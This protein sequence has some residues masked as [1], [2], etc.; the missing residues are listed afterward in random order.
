MKLKFLLP[1]VFFILA[2]VFWGYS[3][4]LKF[5]R[6]QQ[7]NQEL[8]K[9]MKKITRESQSAAQFLNEGDSFSHPISLSLLNDH[10]LELL[11]EGTYLLI[12]ISS[13]CPACLNVAQDLYADLSHFEEYGLR[14]VSLSRDGQEA[15]K[16][17]RSENHWPLPLAYDSAGRLHRLFSISGVPSIVLIH[18]ATVRLKADAM[19]IDRKRPE[20]KELLNLFLGPIGPGR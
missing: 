19:S 4:H 9:E 10:P 11:P 5:S 3:N 12:F 15:L 17:L 18:Q 2:T 13:T 20:L 1:T 6:C 7:A 16:R 14:I 8:M